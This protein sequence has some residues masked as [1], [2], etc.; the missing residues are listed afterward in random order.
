MAESKMTRREFVGRSVAGAA[1]TARRTVVVRVVTTRSAVRVTR[2]LTTLAGVVRTV[3]TVSAVSTGAAA[4]VAAGCAT[5]T[6]DGGAIESS[7]ITVPAG[8][9]VMTVSA[10]W[11]CATEAAARAV[12][13]RAMKQIW[14]LIGNS[15]H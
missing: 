12:T 15:L 5:R 14:F 11:A 3:R 8:G 4:I 6:P 2:R 9:T 13:L 1:A 7:A 10:V